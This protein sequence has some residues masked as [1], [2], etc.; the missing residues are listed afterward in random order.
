MALMESLTQPVDQLQASAEAKTRADRLDS[1]LLQINS[2][3]GRLSSLRQHWHGEQPA[4]YLSQI[5][6]DALDYRLRRLSVNF[7]RLAVLALAERMRLAGVIDQGDNAARPLGVEP[8]AEGLW[9]AL[10]DAGLLD[11]STAVIVDRLFYGTGY[12]TVWATERSRLTITA[13]NSATMTHAADPATGEV[14]YAVRAWSTMAGARSV[15]YEPD[16]ITHYRQPN[17]TE[18]TA[19]NGWVVAGVVDNPLGVVPVVPFVRRVSA[20]DPAT[21]DSV[22][23]DVLDLTDAVG[24][25]LAD[26]MVTSEFYARPRRWATGLEIEYNEDGTPVD[27]FGNSRLL[28]SEAPDTKF[29]QFDAARLDG[30]TDMIATL[31]QQ[32][33]ALTGL[34][35]TYLGLHGDQPASADGVKAAEVQLTMRARSESARMNRGWSDVAWIADAILRTRPAEPAERNRFRVTWES[36]EVRTQAQAADAAAKLAGIGIPLAALLADPLGYSPS[37][38]AGIIGLGVGPVEL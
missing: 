36:P 23:R 34:P 27:P 25:L 11:A 14:E 12:A 37:E 19:G 4:A 3:A 8:R 20:S 38:A 10:T 17:T 29:G 26:A 32:I 30:Y 22:V 33:G 9:D 31:T 16:Q 13:D 35:A 1:G 2:A 6:A 7:P 24:K 18:P 21:G 15:L 5:A 28:Q